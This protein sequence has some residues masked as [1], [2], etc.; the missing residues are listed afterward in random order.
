ML[1]L[2]GKVGYFRSE[3]KATTSV[4]GAL[5]RGSDKQN[6]FTLGVGARYSINR[7]VSLFLE[8]NHYEL[9]DNG[10]AQAWF[11]GARYDF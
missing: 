3:T 7:N 4:G 1:S 5:A 10:D 9:G 6:D 8:G 2:Y 11:L